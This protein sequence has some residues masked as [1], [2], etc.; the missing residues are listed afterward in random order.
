LADSKK[1][2]RQSPIRSISIDN[3]HGKQQNKE[4]LKQKRHEKG[5]IF[6]K[7]KSKLEELKESQKAIKRHSDA[8]IGGFYLL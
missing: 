2:K 3:L 5:Q 4:K 1:L 7:K 8:E 6:G